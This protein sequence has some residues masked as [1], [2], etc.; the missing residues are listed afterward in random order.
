MAEERLT[1]LGERGEARMVD[2]GAKKPTDRRAVARAGLRMS[3]R[4]AR[5]SS[6]PPMRGMFSSASTRSMGTR[7][8]SAMAVAPES[9]VVTR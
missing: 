5:A 2:V 6:A 9:A 1:H 7:C 4:T 3:P 8:S